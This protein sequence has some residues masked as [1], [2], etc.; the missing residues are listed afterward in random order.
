MEKRKVAFLLKFATSAFLSLVSTNLCSAIENWVS[1]DGGVECFTRLG[2]RG[3]GEELW[4]YKRGRKEKEQMLWA[5]DRWI[6]VNWSPDSKF[7]AVIDHYENKESAVLV[8]SIELKKEGI[9]WVL[10]FQTPMETRVP[11]EWGVVKWN[12]DKR[13]IVLTGT[14][15]TL[16]RR[17]RTS[18]AI[19]RVRI[20]TEAIKQSL[21]GRDPETPPLEAEKVDPEKLSPES[22]HEK[23]LESG[24]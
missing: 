10:L 4:I 11:V 20:G 12:V 1:P 2:H 21:Y 24:R 18:P 3:H 23:T 17:K 13:E 8:F 7:L 15:K 6:E 14:P 5:S 16:S 19:A 22:E 9:G